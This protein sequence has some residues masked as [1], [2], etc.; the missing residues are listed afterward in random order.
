MGKQ[1]RSIVTAS[2]ILLFLDTNVLAQPYKK[3]LHETVTHG[4]EGSVKVEGIRTK[5]A[6]TTFNPSQEK[7]MPQ[8][9]KEFGYWTPSVVIFKHYIGERLAECDHKHMLHGIALSSYDWKQW[10]KKDLTNLA[11]S[12]NGVEMF[13]LLE[14]L[15]I[16]AGAKEPTATLT[17]KDIKDAQRALE[18]LKPNVCAD[19][20]EFG[21]WIHSVAKETKEKRE[22]LHERKKESRPTG[23]AGVV[24]EPE[25]M[26]QGVLID[27]TKFN[28]IAGD[29][30]NVLDQQ[31]ALALLVQREVKMDTDHSLVS[32]DPK[33]VAL[34]AVKN[35]KG[36]VRVA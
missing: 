2:C 8:N 12:F 31:K 7:S 5:T 26:K 27:F 13:E 33:A 14:G 22:A 35:I 3:N 1:Y 24:A 36:A 9:D 28:N 25:D 11:T 30:I 32:P 10:T 18:N 19:W 15:K 17:E 20:K 29:P 6:V 21:K 16:A 23:G 4:N 34:E